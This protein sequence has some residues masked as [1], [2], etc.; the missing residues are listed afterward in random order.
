MKMNNP[1]PLRKFIII[2]PNKIHQS[3]FG[4]DTYYSTNTG[5]I[6]AIGPKVKEKLNIG[7]EIV[8]QLQ[9]S[10]YIEEEGWYVVPEESVLYVI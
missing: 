8:F 7:D 6:I 10:T 5:K 1:K 9:G 4:E 2:K 3:D